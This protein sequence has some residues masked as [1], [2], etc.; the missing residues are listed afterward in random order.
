MR[1]S[2]SRPLVDLIGR[3]MSHFEVRWERPVGVE[4][5]QGPLPTPYW[6]MSWG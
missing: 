4:D 2:D 5:N 3:V 6:P 1:G